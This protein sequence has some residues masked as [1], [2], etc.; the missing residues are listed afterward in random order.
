MSDFF[1]L[2]EL[3][4]EYGDGLDADDVYEFVMWWRRSAMMLSSL[5]LILNIVMIIKGKALII[6]PNNISITLSK[7]SFSSNSLHLSDNYQSSLIMKTFKLEENIS[8]GHNKTSIQS[9]RQ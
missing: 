1:I 9:S 7:C 6:K 8:Q 3:L 2:P 4:G 5:F